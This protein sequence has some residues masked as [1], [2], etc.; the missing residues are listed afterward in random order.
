[1]RTP[2]C[3][4]RQ[5]ALQKERG[6]CVKARRQE[7]PWGIPEIERR[8]MRLEPRERDG[9]GWCGE[10]GESVWRAWAHTIQIVMTVAGMRVLGTWKPPTGFV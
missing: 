2:P 4:E 10:R 3:I 1:M 8:P 9:Q 7:R 6:A 5:K